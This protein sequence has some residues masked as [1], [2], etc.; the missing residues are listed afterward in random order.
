MGLYARVSCNAMI[1]YMITVKD[2]EKLAELARISI[3]E[4]EKEGLVKEIDSI[5]TYVEQIKTASQNV[6]NEQSVGSVSNVMRED[7]GSHESGLYTEKILK[8]AP[9]REGDYFKVKKIL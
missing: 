9:R 8:E 4:V 5:L 1:V 6:V 7:D 3:P 2:I